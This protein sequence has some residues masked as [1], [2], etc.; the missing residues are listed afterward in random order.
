MFNLHEKEESDDRF[1]ERLNENVEAMADRR[2]L[3][4]YLFVLGT[5][6]ILLWLSVL[7]FP[8]DVRA[9]FGTV[10]DTNDKLAKVTLALVFGLGMW[11][12][13]S[14]FRLKF[15]DIEEQRLDSEVMGSFAYQEHSTKR[16]A[17]WLFSVVGGILNV[18]FLILA[19]VARS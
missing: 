12:S 3:L 9:G 4:Q 5:L 19:V 8:G 11:L 15:P 10:W 16:W 17:V 7:I 13:Y 18:L 2:Y 6:N 1:A 14:L